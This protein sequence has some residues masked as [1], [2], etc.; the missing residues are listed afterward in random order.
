LFVECLSGSEVGYVGWRRF[1]EG[2][3]GV[4]DLEAWVRLVFPVYRR[5]ATDPQAA[6]RVI[7]R[8]DVNHWFARA[9]GEGRTFSFFPELHKIQCPTLVNGSR[10]PATV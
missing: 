3:L 4:E 5:T 10:T 6:Q 8:P 1:F 7:R 9:R 2:K